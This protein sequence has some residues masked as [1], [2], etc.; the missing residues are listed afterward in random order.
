MRLA[1]VEQMLKATKL[2]GATVIFDKQRFS[3]HGIRMAFRKWL[4]A[5]K[6][7]ACVPGYYL[8][9]HYPNMTKLANRVHRR[10]GC[11]TK[12]VPDL[13]REQF[14]LIAEKVERSRLAPHCQQGR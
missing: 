7:W 12:L 5:H 8:L 13:K 4:T 2:T 6:I 9:A 14:A 3:L 1:A 10:W 11:R